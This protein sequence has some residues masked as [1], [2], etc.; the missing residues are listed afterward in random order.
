[1]SESAVSISTKFD[2]IDRERLASVAQATK[3]SV[4]DVLRQLVRRYLD[5]FERLMLPSGLR[6]ACDDKSEDTTA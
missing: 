3:L 1:M 6:G 5:D 4:S 2:E